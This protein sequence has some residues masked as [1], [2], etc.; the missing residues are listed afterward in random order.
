MTNEHQ[1]KRDPAS[2]K[3]KEPRGTDERSSRERIL[4]V[5]LEEFAD[6][7]LS[8]ARV[9][10]I[11]DRVQTSKRMIYY[12]FSGK[13]ELYRAVLARA[14]E[15]VRS[16]EATMHA[17]LLPPEEALRKIVGATFDHHVSNPAFV[18]LVMNENIHRARHLDLSIRTIN[19]ALIETLRQILERGA[20]SGVF[21]SGIDPLQLRLTIAALSFHYV[22]NRHTFSQG[23]G[24]DMTSPDAVAERRKI[25]IDTVL[26][27]VR[28]PD[29]RAGASGP[30]RAGQGRPAAAKPAGRARPRR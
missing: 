19:N 3:E 29:A 8:G 18:R 22:A 11:A 21:R 24:M 20:R 9:D 7:G 15:G 2:V 14:Y 1:P 4:D 10:E 17:E 23:F 13:E 30:K 28:R 12:H 25:T 26:A 6:K 27:W 5:A 16:Y